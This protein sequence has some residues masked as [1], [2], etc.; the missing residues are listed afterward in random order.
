MLKS[1]KKQ[2]WKKTL[3]AILFYEIFINLVTLG[4]VNKK[5]DA[6]EVNLWDF[7]NLTVFYLFVIYDLYKND[8]VFNVSSLLLRSNLLSLNLNKQKF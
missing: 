6:F 8:S 7:V 4:A 2:E 5:F 1:F 3:L